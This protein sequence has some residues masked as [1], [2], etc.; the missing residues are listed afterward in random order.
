MKKLAVLMTLMLAL[1]GGAL[2]ATTA[3]AAPPQSTAVEVP[4]TG[5][6][7]DALGGTGTFT[8]T[9]TINRVVRDGSEMAAVGTITG[10]A[11]DWAGTTVGTVDQRLTMPLQATAPATSCT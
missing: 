4:V 10:T 7:T 11:T 5:T 8:G 2:V 3:T 9:Y 6:F 1:A